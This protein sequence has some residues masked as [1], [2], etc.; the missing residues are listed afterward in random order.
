M[1]EK[2]KNIF[3]G[4]IGISLITFNLILAAI[5]LSPPLIVQQQDD[6]SYQIIVMEY[7]EICQSN[8]PLID[9]PYYFYSQIALP[10][11]LCNLKNNTLYSIDLGNDKAVYY[12][13]YGKLIN[14]SYINNQILYISL[15]EI[16]NAF[17][18]ETGDLLEVKLSLWSLPQ[19]MN[20]TIL[21]SAYSQYIEI[22]F[23][24]ED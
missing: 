8:S 16:V 1:K 14:S 3:V 24:I 13:F 21:A 5:I 23:G 7:S 22:N 19:E 9:L 4:L 18:F 6:Y 17:K 11:K 10:I 20:N 15:D 12:W 2:N